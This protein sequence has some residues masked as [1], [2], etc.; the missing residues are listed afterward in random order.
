MLR[1]TI[2]PTASRMMLAAACLILAGCAQQKDPPE[3]TISWLAP[4]TRAAEPADCPIP[5]LSALPNT[6]YQQIAVVEVSDDF[7]AS[8]EEVAALVR[9]KACET[10]ADA[11]VI[12]EDQAQKRGESLPGYSGDSQDAMSSSG[13]TNKGPQHAPEVGEV[14][15]RGRYVDAAAIVYKKPPASSPAAATQ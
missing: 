4:R 11:L 15:H 2:C 7:N 9:R 8:N 10:G 5:L 6:D 1:L 14:G 3:A 13:V 12:L